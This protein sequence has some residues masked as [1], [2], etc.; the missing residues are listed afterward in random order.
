MKTRWNIKIKQELMYLTVL[1]EVKV[2]VQY[3]LKAAVQQNVV[4][5]SG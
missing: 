4:K 1:F 3:D 5:T 2:E